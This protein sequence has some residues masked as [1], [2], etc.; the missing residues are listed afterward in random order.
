[1][2]SVY[3]L[4]KFKKQS[5]LIKE[6]AKIISINTH[7]PESSDEVQN[8]AIALYIKEHGNPVRLGP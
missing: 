3:R 4:R 7:L 2:F 6:Y 8:T 1:M 5:Q